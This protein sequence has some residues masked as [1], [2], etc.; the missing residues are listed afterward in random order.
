M[1]TVPSASRYSDCIGKKTVASDVKY[2]FLI[3][4]YLSLYLYLLQQNIPRL[5][6]FK[7]KF[8]H[9]SYV[10]LGQYLHT[11]YVYLS[12]AICRHFQVLKMFLWWRWDGWPKK[13]WVNRSED[14]SSSIGLPCP[15]YGLYGIVRLRIWLAGWHTTY[16]GE[17]PRIC[18]QPLPST[19]PFSSAREIFLSPRD[20]LDW[21]ATQNQ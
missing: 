16:Q 20:S 12:E 18:H 8:V 14:G 5:C 21:Q 6:K 10:R 13:V 7:L 17:P 1:E 4:T 3:W 19:D 2:C 11:V 15:G 9:I